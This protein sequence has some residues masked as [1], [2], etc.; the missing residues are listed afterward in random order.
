MNKPKVSIV[1]RAK[2][3]G[4]YLQKSLPIIF[5]QNTSFQYEVILI[6]S[7]QQITPL[8]FANDFL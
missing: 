6:D 3:C 4:N 1:I 8:N 5:D 7:D 2:N